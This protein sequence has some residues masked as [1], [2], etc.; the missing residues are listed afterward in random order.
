MFFLWHYCVTGAVAVT[1]AR[2]L[3]GG[4]CFTSGGCTLRVR[5][6][7]ASLMG[8]ACFA[9]GEYSLCA[10]AGAVLQCWRTTELLARFCNAG[11]VL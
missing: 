6:I 8:D 7:F 10:V 11:A 1:L 2:L 4:A 9:S 3:V 5:R